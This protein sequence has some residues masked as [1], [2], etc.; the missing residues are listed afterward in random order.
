MQ[1][2]GTL[3]LSPQSRSLDGLAA[4]R[5]DSAPAQRV[6]LASIPSG[7]DGTIATLKVMRDFA[8]AAVRNPDQIIRHKALEIFEREGVPARAWKKEI[9]ALHRFVRDEIRYVRD[10]VDVELVQTPEATLEIRQGDCDDKSTLLAA[11]LMV[12]GHPT[13]FV[14]IGFNGGGFSHVLVETK[15][16][17]TGQDMRDWVPLETILP[18]EPGWYPDGVTSRYVLQV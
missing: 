9:G 1:L 16:N 12:T 11:L 17:H 5:I 18:K 7:R 3:T 15:I 2:R 8:R 14:A 13:R 10:P 4:P 6:Q